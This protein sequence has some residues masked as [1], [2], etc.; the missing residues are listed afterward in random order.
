M[1]IVAFNGDKEENCK[2][3]FLFAKLPEEIFASSS[4]A[5]T[6]P[7]HYHT[8]WGFTLSLLLDERRAG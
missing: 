2:L 8:S 1:S 3:H 6:C 5:A 7:P 4:Q